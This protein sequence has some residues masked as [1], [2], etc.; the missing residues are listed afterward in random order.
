MTRTREA[1]VA[2][3][4]DSVAADEDVRRFEVAVNDTDRVCRFE[5][6][7][8]DT[9]LPDGFMSTTNYPTYV[10]V[11]GQWRMPERPRMARQRRVASSAASDRSSDR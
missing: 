6:A 11:G 7:P 10:H 3:P 9:V 4:N 2:D 5:P 1:K 8:A